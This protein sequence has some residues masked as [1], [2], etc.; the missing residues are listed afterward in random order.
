MAAWLQ[1]KMV[2]WWR[3]SWNFFVRGQNFAQGL[4]CL[5]F[6]LAEDPAAPV[7]G[8]VAADPPWGQPSNGDQQLEELNGFSRQDSEIGYVDSVDPNTTDE[9]I[10]DK[11]TR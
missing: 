3:G 8:W 7:H 9:T 5:G 2:L 10:L 1:I 11:P 4:R 6:T